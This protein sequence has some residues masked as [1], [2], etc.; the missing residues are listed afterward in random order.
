MATWSFGFGAG[1]GGH[2]TGS[3]TQAACYP[4]RVL[5]LLLACT[6]TPGGQDTASSGHDTAPADDALVVVT[7][8]TG[9]TEGIAQQED[10]DGYGPEQAALSDLYY[11]DGLAWS[12][13]VQ[14]TRAFLA[15]VQPDIIAFQEIFWSGACPGIPTEAWPGFVCEAWQ[16]GDPTVAQVILGEGYQVACH[17]DKPDK[18]LAV[19]TA[20]GRFA[21]CEEDLCLDGLDGFPVEGCGSGARVARG[22]IEDLDLTVVGFHGSSGVEAEEQAC[23]VAQVEQVFLDLG[24]GRPGADGARNLVLGDLNTDPSRFADFDDSAA[25]WNDFVG[26]GLPWQWISQ[27]GPDAPGSY[28]GVV[29]I[30]HVAS[31]SFTGECWHGGLDGQPEPYAYALFDHRP[32]VCTVIPR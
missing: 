25:R 31:D 13:A 9:T 1:A 17:P 24:D 10:G 20:R 18:C 8:N 12:A 28:G 21:G 30:D 2:P 29:D 4:L 3:L 5:T 15:Q 14:T 7:F 27:V 6:P 11:G 32:V 19:R 23:R 16:Q 26:E 22:R